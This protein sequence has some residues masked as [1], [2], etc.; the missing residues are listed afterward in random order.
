MKLRTILVAS[1][2][3][4][5]AA[6][7]AAVAQT[8]PISGGTEVGGVAPSFLELILTQ[9]AKGFASFAKTKSYSMSFNVAATATDSPT[10][11]SIVDGD[12][13]R[14]KKLGHISVGHKRLPSPLEAK[15]KGAYQP[16]DD[17][18]DPL[19]ASWSDV[20]TRSEK[21]IRLR[22]KVKGKAKGNYHK[23]VLVTLSTET[24]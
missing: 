8:P 6:P 17:S 24:P 4:A 2:I 15:V 1:A 22:Q 13:T 9:P 7:S 10:Q 20:M 19:L 5:M 16:L 12:E 14:G 21:K 11:L 3:A 23:L 18:V